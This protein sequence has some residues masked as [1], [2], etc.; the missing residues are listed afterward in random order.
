MNTGHELK[1]NIESDEE[2]GQ[3]AVVTG[4]PLTYKY[5][6]HHLSIHFGKKDYFG[7]EHLVNGTSF[8]LEVGR[9]YDLWKY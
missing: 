7:S 6:L 2:T 4:G 5:R 9:F 3:S 8:P 1:L